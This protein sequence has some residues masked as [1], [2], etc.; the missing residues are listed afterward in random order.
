MAPEARLD[1][2]TGSDVRQ[3]VLDIG[4][5]KED[6]GHRPADDTERATTD[7]IAWLHAGNKR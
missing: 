1:L 5:L 7:H 4:R 2:P 3:P 6:T